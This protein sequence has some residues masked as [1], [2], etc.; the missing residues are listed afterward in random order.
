MT[1]HKQLIKHDPK[2]DAYGDCWR[3][4]IACLL[5]LHPSQVPH[6]CADGV[7]QATA[8]AD[9]RAWL[10]ERGYNL[11]RTCMFAKYSEMAADWFGEAMYILCGASP[12]HPGVGHCVIG[13]GGF[14]IVWDVGQSGA[15]LAGPWVDDNGNGIY[16][17]EFIVPRAEMVLLEAA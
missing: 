17:C 3:T 8:D 15:G 2:N 10:K 12:N 7:S 6:F 11:V 14:E 5:D 4:C 1:P 9:C 16:W 13:R